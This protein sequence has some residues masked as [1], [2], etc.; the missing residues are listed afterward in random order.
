MENH[1]LKPE[2]TYSYNLY[3]LLIV[4]L[5]IIIVLSVRRILTVC[6]YRFTLCARTVL[7]FVPCDGCP[8]CLLSTLVT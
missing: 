3:N 1:A 7:P 5:V 4:Q 6:P 2:P 8:S